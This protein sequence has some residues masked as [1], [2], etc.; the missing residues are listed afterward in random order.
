MEEDS[1]TSAFRRI[2]WRLRLSAIRLTGTSDDA[3]DALQEA[4]FRLWKR[5]DRIGSREQA[6]RMLTAAVRNA[7]IDTLRGRTHAASAEDIPEMPDTDHGDDRAE[8]LDEVTRL[9]DSELTAE[10]RA[11]LYERDRYGWEFD[12]IARRHGMSEANVRMTVSRCRR[13]VR[14]LYLQN[15]RQ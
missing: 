8:L 3:D 2:G 13:K 5:R 4:F 9:I 12:E 10:Q 7:G 11:I 14:E 15:Q 1:L 6:E